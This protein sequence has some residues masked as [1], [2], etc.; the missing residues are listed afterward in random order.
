MREDSGEPFRVSCP[1]VRI[2]S[3]SLNVNSSASE[4]NSCW[5]VTKQKKKPVHF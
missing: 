3:F 4:K 5:L 1:L 2:S